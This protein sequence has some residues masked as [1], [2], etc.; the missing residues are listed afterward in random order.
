VTGSKAVVV[1]TGAGGMG[2]AIARRIGGGATVILADFD[3]QAL[4]SA[5][6]PLTV[7]GFDVVRRVVEVSRKDSVD[8]LAADAAARGPVTAVVH[9]AGVSPVQATVDAIMHV[10]LLG[11]A[12]MLDA[13]GA[14]ISSGGAGVFISSMA[15]TMTSLDPDLE[16]RLATTPT[17][18][19]LELD[20]LAPGAVA[21]PGTAYG[22]A[23]RANQVRV[24]A[25]S[26][27]WGQ[28]GAR[29]NSISPGVIATPMGTA[30]L[31]GPH[32]D[33]MR[34][35]IAG[36]GTGRIGTPEDIAG[37]VDFLASRHASFITGT[38]VL[39]DG[40]VIASLRAPES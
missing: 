4:E 23:K 25:A 7:A 2:G 18:Q 35:M 19:L 10:D 32:G 28:R 6:T 20:E 27:W 1:V 38:D 40:G 8:G 22:I 21:D 9:T 34:A 36:S 3:E 33:F 24:M 26:R 37:V 29:V 11:T 13:F 14:V 17:D 30:E 31:D 5:A 39:V 15:G 16:L 12:L